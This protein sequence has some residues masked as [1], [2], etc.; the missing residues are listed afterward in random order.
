MLAIT[1]LNYVPN[2][3]NL[4][5]QEE[6][7]HQI[8]QMP[9]LTDLRRR[10]QHYGYKYDYT[11]KQID[12]SMRVGDIPSWIKEHCQKL[13]DDKIFEEIP[14]QVIVNEYKPGQGISRHIDCVPCFSDTICSL[15]LASACAM[16]FQSTKDWQKQ[17]LTLEPGSLLVL[18]DEARY[19]WMHSIGAVKDYRI[20]LTFRK[21]LI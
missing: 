21:V 11:K 2:Y 15:S 19:K 4:K 18:K 16:D 7:I 17:K 12:A 8:N 20:S 1:G 10:T 5:Q 9:W 14:D 6:L 3:I 13:V